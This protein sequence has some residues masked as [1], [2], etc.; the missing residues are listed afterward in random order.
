MKLRFTGQKAPTE[1][2]Q[3]LIVMRYTSQRLHLI[4]YVVS[5]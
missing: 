1:T 4:N 5:N 2:I 3:A